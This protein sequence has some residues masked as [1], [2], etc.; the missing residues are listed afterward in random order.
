[1]PD[2]AAPADDALDGIVIRSTGSWYDVRVDDGRMVPAKVRGK[3][4]LAEGSATNPVA[5]GDRVT[6]LLNADDTGWITDIH[7]RGNKLSRR[8][9][10][11]RVGREHV[12]VANIDRAWV[13]QSV[14]LPKPNPGFVDRFLV[15]AEA[16]DIPA[17]LVLNKVDLLA[18]D[19]EADIDALA[20]LYRSLDYPVLLTSAEDGAGMNDL[21]E[22]LRDRVSVV[23][24]PSGVGKSTLLN[25]VEPTLDL[26]TAEVSQKTRKGR[27]TTTNAAL[28]PLA[29][30]GYVVDTPGIR[31]FG[32][33]DLDAAELGHCFVEFRP[34]A[35]ACYFP[36][37]THDHE[38]DCAVKAAV[39]AG[40]ISEQRY[41][42]YLNMLD[43]LHLGLEQ[44]GR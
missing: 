3:F 32:L 22:A 40:V 12:L 37:C 23:A 10:G 9:A 41:R 35:G 20:S 28:Y 39:E 36:N 8:A 44:R 33:I 4:R 38:P 14:R 11:R 24:G 27:H 30:G 17:G 31:E 6:L 25:R 5:V 43:S 7:P 29:F 19:D 21:M 13:V 26:R 18:P 42:S 34:H 2:P 15:M 1:M 16:N